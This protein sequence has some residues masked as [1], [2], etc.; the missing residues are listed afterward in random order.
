MDKAKPWQER[1]W[2]TLVEIKGITDA[3]PAKYAEISRTLI[4]VLLPVQFKNYE[5]KFS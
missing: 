4:D 2:V 1:L 3:F 5:G